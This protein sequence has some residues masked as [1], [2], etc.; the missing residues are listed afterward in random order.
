MRPS[1]PRMLWGAFASGRPYQVAPPTFVPAEAQLA[2]VRSSRV[3]SPGSFL[4]S[5]SG[6]SLTSSCAHEW[7]SSVHTLKLTKVLGPNV[8][9]IGT[10]AASRP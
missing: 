5:D 3:A 9:V 10:S 6:L 8:W 1:F 4:W 2:F 7:I